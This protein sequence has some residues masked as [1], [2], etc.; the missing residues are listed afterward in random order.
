M[1]GGLVN[2]IGINKFASSAE[3]TLTLDFASFAFT[4]GNGGASNPTG[5]NGAAWSFTIPAGSTNIKISALGGGSGQV[6]NDTYG[7]I[8][9]SSGAGALITDDANSGTSLATQT[10]LC[11]VAAGGISG[12][13]TREGGWGNGS[14]GL[15]TTVQYDPDAEY[16]GGGGGCS[17]VAIGATVILAVRGGDSGYTG[18]EV[19]G[20]PGINAVII[21]GEN[22]ASSTYFTAPPTVNYGSNAG[23]G[24][25]AGGN[26]QMII[27]YTK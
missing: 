12:S 10:L 23:S 8:A 3:H 15:G 19:V 21:N 17:T 4:G 25:T 18:G 1:M 9:D 11:S 2:M 16:A 26:G 14:G 22:Y 27:K 6:W 24:V 13:G 7:Y 5:G 20:A